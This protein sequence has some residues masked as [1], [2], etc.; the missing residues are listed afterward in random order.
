MHP[1]DTMSIAIDWASKYILFSL[2]KLKL[3][4]CSFYRFEVPQVTPIPKGLN[5]INR[6]A[7]LCRGLIDHY[8][9]AKFLFLSEAFQQDSNLSLSVLFNHLYYNLA[10][11]FTKSKN[12]HI[13]MDNC[14]GQ[15]KNC[16]VMVF[17]AFLVQI[18]WF[19]SVE[20]AFLLTG[21][22]SSI[23]DILKKLYYIAL[24]YSFL[25]RTY[26]H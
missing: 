23:S 6:P 1:E 15:N 22:L 4:T 5:N 13:Q 11:G 18:G 25:F 7:Y 17:C 14:S 20:L 8:Q 9:G 21:L 3:F 19:F 16:Y 10:S 2:P 24:S 26:S 12:L